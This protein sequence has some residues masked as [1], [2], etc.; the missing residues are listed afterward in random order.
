M[1]IKNNTYF[2]PMPRKTIINNFYFKIKLL[3]LVLLSL[4]MIG[5]SIVLYKTMCFSTNRLSVLFYRMILW[6]LSIKVTYE[7]DFIKANKCNFFVSNHVSYLDIPI[8]GSNIPLRFIAKSEVETWALFGFLAKLAQTIFIKRLRTESKKQKNRLYEALLK[9]DKIIGFP[10][11]TTSD[12]NRVLTFKSSFFSALENKNFLIQPIV[13]VYSHVNNIPINRWLRPVIA[14]YGDMELIPHLM[15][16]ASFSSIKVSVIYLNPINTNSFENRKEI[17]DYL[18]KK[19][20][21]SYSIALN[22]K[23]LAN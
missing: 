3:L 12:G 21:E 18:E 11:G 16:C 1:K 4:P 22:R 20:Q 9:G 14:W 5:L 6:L 19:I 15:V 7:G 2:N 13:V 8:L 17:S 23:K 10:E